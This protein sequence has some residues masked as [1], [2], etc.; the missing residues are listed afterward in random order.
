MSQH[1]EGSH[2]NHDDNHGEHH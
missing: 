2:E 1:S